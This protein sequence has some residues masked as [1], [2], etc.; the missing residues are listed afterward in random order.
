MRLLIASVMFGNISI[1]GARE[2]FTI[3]SSHSEPLFSW[4][5]DIDFR[6]GINTEN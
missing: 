6:M 5:K 1:T 2:L 4:P 3:N